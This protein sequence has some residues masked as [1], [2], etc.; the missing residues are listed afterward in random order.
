MNKNRIRTLGFQ[1]ASGTNTLQADL[2]GWYDREATDTKD[3]LKIGIDAQGRIK[4]VDLAYF[5]LMTR[6]IM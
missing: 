2:K 3:P 4:P 1:L 6:W 5:S